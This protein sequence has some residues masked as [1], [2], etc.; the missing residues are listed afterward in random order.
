MNGGFHSRFRQHFACQVSDRVSIGV[1][2]A[3]RRGCDADVAGEEYEVSGRRK[4]VGE[5]RKRLLCASLHARRHHDH[6]H[7]HEHNRN[8]KHHQQISCFSFIHWLYE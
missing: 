3:V 2:P 1:A 5:E 8:Y 6:H 7:R 4:I